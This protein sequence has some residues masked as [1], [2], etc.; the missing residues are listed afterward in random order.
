[1]LFSQRCPSQLREVD[2]TALGE[3]KEKTR[4]KHRIGVKLQ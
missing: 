2:S 4:V 1:M 3:D